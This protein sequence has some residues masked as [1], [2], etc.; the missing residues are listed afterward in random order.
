MSTGIS[1]I[2]RLRAAMSA[3]GDVAYDWDYAGHKICLLHNTVR[4]FQ[5]AS[6][7]PEIDIS[8][9]HERVHPEDLLVRLDAI[10]ALTREAPFIESEFRLLDLARN[11]SLE[12]VAEFVET[13][14]QARILHKEGV[15]LLQGWAFGKPELEPPWAAGDG[16]TGG[17]VLLR[18][19]GGGEG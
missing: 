7:E 5:L 3:A 9:F 16:E 19:A 12:T 17:E 1:E 11:F 13:E 10:A 6:D 2:E 15:D 8:R 4:S 18:L 14:E